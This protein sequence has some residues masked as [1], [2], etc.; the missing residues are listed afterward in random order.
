MNFFGDSRD[1]RRIFFLQYFTSAIFFNV[2]ILIFFNVFHFWFNSFPL[3]SYTLTLPVRKGQLVLHISNQSRTDDY[4][5]LWLKGRGHDLGWKQFI[6]EML[7]WD[8]FNGQRWMSVIE[9]YERYS[10]Q[11]RVLQTSLVLFLFTFVERIYTSNS[12]VY[13]KCFFSLLNCF[14]T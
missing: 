3:K 6:F 7:H 8:T 1:F 12:S 10:S 9:Q 14:K 13:E 4:R 11:F 5:L 2:H